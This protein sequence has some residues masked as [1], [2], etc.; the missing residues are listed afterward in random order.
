MNGYKENKFLKLTFSGQQIISIP[1]KNETLLLI[2]HNLLLY[3]GFRRHALIMKHY[4]RAITIKTQTIKFFLLF[5]LNKYSHL[6]L[7]FMPKIQLWNIAND[8]IYFFGSKKGPTLI[9]TL[10]YF[11]LEKLTLNIL[12]R[13]EI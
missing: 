13:N 4:Q 2:K 12:I 8:Y 5:M 9:C 6:F 10:P 3:S 1:F 11:L 7:I